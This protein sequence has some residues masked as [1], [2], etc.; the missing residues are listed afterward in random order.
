MLQVLNFDDF[1]RKPLNNKKPAHMSAFNNSDHS[2]NASVN[3]TS[4]CGDKL[5]FVAPIAIL[6]TSLTG[7]GPQQ[8][9]ILQVQTSRVT[10]PLP[11][12]F[13]ACGYKLLHV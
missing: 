9:E 7:I 5:D 2:H 1:V 10:I 12:S 6:D 11:I 8:C 3:S 4:I 13:I